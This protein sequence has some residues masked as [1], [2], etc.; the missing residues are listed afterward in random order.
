MVRLGLLALALVGCSRP[1]AAVTSEAGTTDAV[2]PI[3][4]QANADAEPRSVPTRAR[5]PAGEATRA[6]LEHLEDE[7][8]LAPGLAKLHEHFADASGPFL[9]QRAALS[10]GWTAMLVS[11]AD[12][13]QPAVIVVDRDRLV[14]AKDK[15]T[16]GIVTP[17]GQLALVPYADGGVALVACVP[18]ASLVAARVWA[19]DA[20]PF[21]ELELLMGGA[22][23]AVSAA[24]W[25]GEG[26][27]VVASRAAESR[28]QL[29]R[30]SGSLAWGRDGVSVGAAW[31]A[32]APATLVVDTPSSVMLLQHA[33]GAGGGDHLVAQRYDDTGSALWSKPLDV[34]LVWHVSPPGQRVRASPSASRSGVVRVDLPAGVPTRAAKALEVDAA[35]NVTWGPR[36]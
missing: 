26:W 27:V 30:E 23:E 24:Y 35:G 12:E 10:N 29:L 36:P 18:G 9:E 2:A 20:N 1:S 8:L 3:A 17:V 6:V 21:A 34:G 32:P 28:A 33:S 14:W 11:R 5:P 31:R 16:A 7:P 13:S 25:P 22:C 15:P 4:S 19:D